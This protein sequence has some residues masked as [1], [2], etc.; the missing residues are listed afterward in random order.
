[1]RLVRLRPKQPFSEIVDAIAANIGAA[2][3]QSC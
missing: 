2:S 1:M 3:A